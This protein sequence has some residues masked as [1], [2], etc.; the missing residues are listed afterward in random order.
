MTCKYLST[1][2]RIIPGNVEVGGPI[3]PQKTSMPACKLKRKPGIL[4][5]AK[6]CNETPRN[7]PCWFWIEEHGKAQDIQFAKSPE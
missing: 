4:F 5:W 3:T 6:K 1:E 7:G 2:T